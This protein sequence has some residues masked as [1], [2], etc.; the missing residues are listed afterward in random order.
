MSAH[1]PGRS[2]GI[3]VVKCGGSGALDVTRLC[4]DVAERTAAGQ[5]L[6]LVHGGSAE[7]ERL[8]GQLGVR[9]RHLT[10]PDGVVT[11]YT[12]DA[13]LDVLTLALAGRVKPGLLCALDRH[14]VPAVGLTGLD[15]GLLR[16]RRRRSVRAVVDGRPTVVRDDR[17]GR[18]VEVNAGLL[19]GLLAAGVVPVVS[20]PALAEDSEPVNTN[21]DRA[22]A[23][24][25]VALRARCLVFL[26]GAPGVLTDPSDPS[27][28]LAAYRLPPVGEPAPSWV[29][30]GMR[31]KLVA[32]REALLGG[33]PEVWI[34]DAA[35]KRPLRV[36]SGGGP[37]SSIVLP[38]VP[39]P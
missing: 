4:E 29:A 17:G 8:A 15:A 38:G 1:A 28:V 23:A 10:A 30:G 20:P 19:H 32:A 2:Q 9:L 12:D 37:G 31:I 5:K 16:A 34:T 22:A 24:V 27:S 25:A 14:K 26:T 13:T 11:R 18:I 3:V 36:L 39:S 6:V 7:M 21:A 35:A 33:V